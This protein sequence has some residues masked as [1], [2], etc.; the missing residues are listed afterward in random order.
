V[1]PQPPS[2][3]VFGLKGGTWLHNT[4]RDL[5]IFSTLSIISK[6]RLTPLEKVTNSCWG[7]KSYKRPLL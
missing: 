7:L 3:S 5:I 1:T 6:L 2:S 4:A